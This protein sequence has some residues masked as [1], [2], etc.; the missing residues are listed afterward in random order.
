MVSAFS[1]D[2]DQYV[3]RGGQAHQEH[4]NLGSVDEREYKKALQI[5]RDFHLRTPLSLG[6]IYEDREGLDHQYGTKSPTAIRRQTTAR[7][8]L[9]LVEPGTEAG[10][11][12]PERSSFAEPEFSC[13]TCHLNADSVTFQK[14]PLGRPPCRSRS[15]KF[16]TP[17]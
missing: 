17:R 4:R 16:W 7:N 8:L 14:P 15:T 1:A 13:R 2:S 9:Q 6:V 5:L 3:C 11:G 10:Y 12:E